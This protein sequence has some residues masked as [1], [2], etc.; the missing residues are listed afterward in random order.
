[1]SGPGELIDVL[2][3]LFD[4]LVGTGGPIYVSPP[5]PGWDPVIAP[6]SGTLEDPYHSISTALAMAEGGRNVYLRGGQY[7]EEVSAEGV[8]GSENNVIVVKPYRHEPVTIDCVVEDFLHPTDEAFWRK[9]DDGGEDE[10]VW[11]K[12]FPGNEDDWIRRG[13]FLDTHRH[14]RLVT[15]DHPE[16][17][18]AANDLDPRDLTEGGDNQVWK[19][20]TDPETGEAELKPTG[21]FR[22]WVYM[23]P[24]LWFDANPDRRTVHLRMSHTHNHVIGWPDYTGPT[25]PNHVKLALSREHSHALFLH[26][27]QHITFHDLDLRFG[28]EDTVRL[29]NCHNIEFDHVNIRAA[30]RAI[31]LEVND[32]PLPDGTE[33]RNTDIVFQ[34]C[35]IDGGTP[36]WFFRSDRKDSYF[37][38]PAADPDG[39]EPEENRLGFSTTGVLVSSRR[40]A[41][42]IQ[43]HHCKI[44]NG[45]DVCVFGEQMR[46]HHNWVHNINDDALFIA[47]EDR[48]DHAWIYRNVITQCLSALS[49]A[50]DDPVGHIRIFRNLIDLRQPTLGVRP[51]R[52]CYN[53]LRQGQLYKSDGVEGP[54]DLWHNTC[55]TLNGGATFDTGEPADL[56][57]A[58]FTHYRIFQGAGTRRAFNNLFVAAYPIE[59][60]TQPIAFLPTADSGPTDGNT[61]Y[62]A[63]P[64]APT[65]AAFTVTGDSTPYPTMESYQAKYDWEGGGRLLNPNFVSFDTTTGYPAPDDDL[66]LQGGNAAMTAIGMEDDMEDVEREAGGF[67]ATFFGHERGCY[68]GSWD[69]LRVG[70]DGNDV[71]P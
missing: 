7:V 9:V 2:G 54:F 32:Q 25:D 70:V 66:R 67:L 57:R 14:T 38:T 68:W 34:H 26:G 53:P 12:S 30:S 40:N 13:A 46:F 56:N 49:F 31:R 33:E 71:F 43:I 28:G 55:L 47:S 51:R 21:T 16:D 42:N 45:H 37:Y 52:P 64:P 27:C 19:A 59:G 69:R 18:R 20:V 15:Y 60:V 22:N 29:R 41:S 39:T 3:D 36:T 5:P 1:M 23:G 44:F 24:G 58:G 6:G 4:E 11:T 48:A 63:G 61:Y 10:Y 62:R 35:E 50:A 8:S 65:V 17:L